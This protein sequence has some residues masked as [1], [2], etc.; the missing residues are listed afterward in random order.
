MFTYLKK[1]KLFLL[2][3]NILMFKKG[4]S[5]LSMKK[6]MT[7]KHSGL[8]RFWRGGGECLYSC[9]YKTF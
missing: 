9:P 1:K 7:L 5:V 3:L 2:L 8:S 6:I 4:Q